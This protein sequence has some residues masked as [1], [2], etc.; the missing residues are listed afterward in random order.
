MTPVLPLEVRAQHSN[1]TRD[2]YSVTDARVRI[3]FRRSADGSMGDRLGTGLQAM[4]LSPCHAGLAG[5][6][7]SAPF[8]RLPLLRHA[9]VP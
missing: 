5:L 6:R 2:I 4:Q 1:E 9:I 7:L 3:V 8:L